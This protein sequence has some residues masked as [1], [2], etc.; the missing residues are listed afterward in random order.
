[1]PDTGERDE[2]GMAPIDGLFSSPEKQTPNGD[3]TGEMD[4]DIESGMLFHIVFES[5]G[6]LPPSLALVR[7]IGLGE[8]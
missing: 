4:M 2:H 5:L 8:Y 3:D 6:C 7:W 1:M